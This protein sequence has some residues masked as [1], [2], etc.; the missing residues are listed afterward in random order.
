[1]SEIGK[2]IR[3]WTNRENIMAKNAPKLIRHFNYSIQENKAYNCVTVAGG[4]TPQLAAR[5]RY[6]KQMYAKAH[7]VQ[8]GHLRIYFSSDIPVG[9]YHP[10]VGAL[11]LDNLWTR[12]TAYH[13][14][15]INSNNDSR[16]SVNHFYN[17][18]NKYLKLETI[19][20]SKL[21]IPRID[22]YSL[23]DKIANSKYISQHIW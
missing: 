17:I 12:Q 19:K 21:Y 10:E 20:D 14:N 22:E 8:I 11:C 15:R 7:G 1:M 16:M 4:I 2:E 9:F 23:R 3:L 5:T 18:L 6:I 13:L